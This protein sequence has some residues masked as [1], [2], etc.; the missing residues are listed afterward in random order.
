MAEVSGH[1]QPQAWDAATGEIH[2]MTGATAGKDSLHLRLALQPY[3]AKFVVIGTAPKPV[4]APEP[5]LAGGEIMIE[6]PVDKPVTQFTDQVTLAFKPA[7]K[8]VY[9]ECAD[10]HD[11]ASLRINGKEVS[12]RAW[13]PY[14]WDVTDAL[15]T[16]VNRIEIQ[17]RTL[18]AGGRGGMGG[19]A[20]SAAEAAPGA[21]RGPGAGA[22]PAGGDPPAGGRGPAT[23]PPVPGLFGAVRLVAR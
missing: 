20:P 5:P 8:R 6:F 17:V 3:E 2:L 9:V 15:S 21:G 1:G 22:A 16:G 18:P 4:A 10:I 19:P 7:G 13:Q 14:R 11:Y 12:A 23:P